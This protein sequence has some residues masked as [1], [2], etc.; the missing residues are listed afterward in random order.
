MGY[1]V[2]NSPRTITRTGKR[3]SDNAAANF[4]EDAGLQMISDWIVGYGD[5]WSPEAVLNTHVSDV[6]MKNAG[7]SDDVIAWW[8]SLSQQDQVAYLSEFKQDPSLVDKIFGG[9]AANDPD[10]PNS[11][12]VVGDNDYYD[13]TGFFKKL[14]ELN[15][16]AEYWNTY[17][18]ATPPSLLDYF[19]KDYASVADAYKDMVGEYGIVGKDAN[20]NDILYTNFADYINSLGITGIQD[21]DVYLDMVYDDAG[22][23]NYDALEA[24]ALAEQDAI[25]AALDDS[26]ALQQGLLGDI[27][28]EMAEMTDLYNDSLKHQRAMYNRQ[29]SN[30]LS[31][32]YLTNA[33][34]ADVLRSDMRRARQNAL[35]AGASAGIRLANNVNTLLTSQN[36]QSATAMQTSNALA[37]MLL[38]QRSAEA[39]LRSDYR[40]DKSTINARKDGIV[41]NIGNLGVQRAGAAAEKS[42]ISQNYKSLT[43]QAIANLQGF[44]SAKYN[45][46]WNTWGAMDSGWNSRNATFNSAYNAYK[47]GVD[48]YNTDRDYWEGNRSAIEGTNT[49]ADDYSGYRY[50]GYIAR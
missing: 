47:A 25:I 45:E 21:R 15:S 50:N 5:G 39:G 11:G 8:N 24:Q 1:T 36:K 27:N 13:L 33:K 29:A 37:E 4:F 14:S 35:E 42:K 7:V 9:V 31:N 34:T 48:A 19:G 2:I 30:L 38:Q 6:A 20:G 22:M 17:D 12:G 43:E 18:N 32:Q 3:R 23:Y 10:H 28:T 46:A 41:S 49:W 44:D 16:V 40:S 26:I